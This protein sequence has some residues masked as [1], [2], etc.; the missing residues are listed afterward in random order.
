MFFS[1]KV[2]TKGDPETKQ[3][4]MYDRRPRSTRMCTY[5]RIDLALVT[6]T[7]H[8]NHF[9]TVLAIYTKE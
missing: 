3:T 4:V 8:L 9:N 7:F 2:F 5:S 1:G 6:H